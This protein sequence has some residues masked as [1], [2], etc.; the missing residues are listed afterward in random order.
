MANRLNYNDLLKYMEIVLDMEKNIYIQQQTIKKV[1]SLTNGLGI[2]NNYTKP[3]VPQ[4]PTLKNIEQKNEKWN[5]MPTA[6]FE[7][8][9]I[10]GAITSAIILVLVL[11]VERDIVV[12]LFSSLGNMLLFGSGTIAFVFMIILIWAVILDIKNEKRRIKEKQQSEI[13]NQKSREAA[14]QKNLVQ[15]NQKL[16]QY[17]QK[18]G[19]DKQRVQRE[20]AQKQYLE[21]QCGMLTIILKTSKAKLEQIYDY[22]ILEKKYRNIVAVASLYEYLKHERTRSLQ[23]TGNDEGA[24]NIYEME[25]RLNKIVTNTDTIIQKL[26]VVIKNQYEIADTLREAKNSIDNLVISVNNASKQLSN[27]INN[28]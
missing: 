17:N 6:Y 4:Q 27:R 13:N 24:Y 15:Y 12:W 22:D 18:V 8:A 5:L 16:N 3:Q 19:N 9:I 28:R 23:R 10:P 14:Y 11:T 26:D 7:D 2:A 20:L 25:I 1:K 21:E